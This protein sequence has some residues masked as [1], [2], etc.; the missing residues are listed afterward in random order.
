MQYKMVTFDLD[1]TLM[2]S[3]SRLSKESIE[4]I[5]EY[6]RRG[7]PFVPCTGRTLSEMPEIMENPDIRYI[8]YS[9]GSA[10][11]DKKTG[12]VV[13]HGLSDREKEDLLSLLAHY[14]VYILLHAN[15]N[16]YV[17]KAFRGR[18]QEHNICLPVCYIIEHVAI[19][20]EN[21]A[22]YIL[23]NEIEYITVFFQ[24][25]KEQ[26]A[27]RTELLKD[28]RLI[29]A[30]PWNA[31]FEIFSKKAGKGNGILTLCDKLG[32]AP[33]EVIAVGDSDNDALALKTAGR[34]IAVSNGTDAIKAMADEI[35]CSNDECVARYVLEKY[36]M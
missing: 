26:E 9:S 32:I 35:A 16:T 2:G 5:K 18:E 4:A 29:F 36:F 10:I 15:G 31:N 22:S 3:D 7:I 23:E 14:K 20:K 12:E 34:A 24:D 21:L 30:E 27:C 25:A 8:I 28:E 17:D 6:K 19:E 13:S 33:E 11:L 1:G